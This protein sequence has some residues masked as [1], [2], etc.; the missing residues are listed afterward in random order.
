[1]RSIDSFIAQN[2]FGLGPAPGEEARIGDDPRGWVLAQIDPVQGVAPLYQRRLTSLEIL[3]DIH[4]AR[5][6][7]NA[8]REAAIRDAMQHEFNPSLV[9]RA[10]LSIATRTPLVDRM[11]LFW[12]NHF[13]VST[14][15]RL[16]APALPAYEREVIAHHIFGRFAD[17]LRAVIRHP[18]MLT[19]LDNI[20]SIGPNSLVGRRRRR[21]G[22]DQTL[23]ENLAREV[24]ELHTL[25]VDGGYTQADVIELAKVLSGWSHGGLRPRSDARP[26]QGGFEFR[27][28]NHE[29]GAKTILGRRYHEAGAD[30]GLAV[31]D[32]LARHPATARHIAT[33]LVRHFV[34]DAPPDEAVSRI[35][36]VFIDSD[37]DLAEVMRAL[38]ALEQV[39]RDPIPKVRTPY[40]Y[41]IAVHRAS[42]R[43]RASQRDIF[44][45]LR[46]LGQFPF[47]A[48]SPQGWG[49]TAADWIAPESLMRR[50]EWTRRFAAR[51]P[52][53]LVPARFLDDTVG[54]VA[55]D[56]LH[57]AV[58]Q[59][60]SGDAGLAMILASPEFQRR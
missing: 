49:D 31:L 50:I 9:I 7:N 18:C 4:T 27:A 36:R 29:P 39:W 55:S 13:T 51:L 54:P 38:V 48:P 8:A 53:S 47:A 15:R 6:E 34:A 3:R 2:R 5:R 52:A 26:V 59:A 28:E 56:A 57:R 17:M 1:M 19:Y 58:A 33:K 41:V 45:P 14:T 24:L 35:A 22:N 37:G 60:A 12:S 43:I 44:Q 16:I 30:E 25:G 46:L 11:T 32:D 20:A 42:G 23:N 40:E 10:R 21:R